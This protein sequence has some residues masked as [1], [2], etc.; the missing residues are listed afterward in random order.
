MFPW[1]LGIGGG[2][3]VIHLEKSEN[4]CGQGVVDWIVILKEKQ[5]DDFVGVGKKIRKV[6]LAGEEPTE[7]YQ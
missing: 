7:M 2:D 6:S 1:S 3:G 5:N 4:H